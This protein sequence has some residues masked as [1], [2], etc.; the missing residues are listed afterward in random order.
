MGFELFL[1]SHR[2]L[3]KLDVYCTLCTRNSALR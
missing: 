3:D 2:T 1:A